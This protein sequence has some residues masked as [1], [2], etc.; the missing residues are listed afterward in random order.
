[1]SYTQGGCHVTEAGDIFE[2]AGACKDLT[3]NLCLVG[4]YPTAPTKTAVA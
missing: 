3:L 2:L 4:I 1:M